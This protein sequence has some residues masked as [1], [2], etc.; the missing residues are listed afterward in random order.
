MTLLVGRKV[1]PV[2]RRSLSTEC[3]SLQKFKKGI[4]AVRPNYTLQKIGEALDNREKGSVVSQNLGR[5][6]D[7][8]C[9]HLLLQ[10][11]KAYKVLGSILEVNPV[12]VYW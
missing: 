5:A 10:K 4:Y 9:L 11:P 2:Y 1:I 6:F 3:S 8:I 7:T 12:Y